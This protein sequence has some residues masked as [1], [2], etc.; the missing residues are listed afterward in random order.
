MHKNDLSV[1][2]YAEV[3]EMLAQI[4]CVAKNYGLPERQSTKT[5]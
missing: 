2:F 1:T 3:Q 4:F 5:L